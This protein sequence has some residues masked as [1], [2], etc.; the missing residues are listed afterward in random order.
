M[1]KFFRM[2]Q[3][4][5]PKRQ[6]GIGLIEVLV[7]T[8]IIGIVMIAVARSYVSSLSGLH[9][10]NNTTVVTQLVDEMAENIR[11][12]ESGAAFYSLGEKTDQDCYKNG[13]DP[14][15]L[16]GFQIAEFNKSAA[17]ILYNHVLQVGEV[18]QNTVQVT[19]F[20]DADRSGSTVTTQCPPDPENDEHMDCYRI[21]VGL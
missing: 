20:W 6:Q 21:I 2:K 19:L 18:V 13:C 1:M 11:A 7:S 15:D 8:V 4:V 16:A 5:R 14:E 3:I 12:N 9:Q 17:N 10:S